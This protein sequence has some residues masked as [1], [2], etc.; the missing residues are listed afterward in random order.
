MLSIGFFSGLFYFYQHGCYADVEQQYDKT[1]LEGDKIKTAH[2]CFLNNTSNMMLRVRTRGFM[3]AIKINV[4]IFSSIK[5]RLRRRKIQRVFYVQGGA[6][7]R[8]SACMC[9]HAIRILCK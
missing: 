5:I 4:K 7:L 9:A 8:G 6:K 1:N 2:T 3:V